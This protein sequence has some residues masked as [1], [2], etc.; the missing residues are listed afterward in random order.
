MSSILVLTLKIMD[1]SILL[2]LFMWGLRF[3]ACHWV[4]LNKY[5]VFVFPSA[6]WF[7]VSWNLFIIS[8]GVGVVFRL[9]FCLVW[10]YIVVSFH[11]PFSLL[12]IYTFVVMLL[13]CL[14]SLFSMF[15]LFLVVHK[16]L[17]VVFWD[18]SSCMDL[19]RV[20]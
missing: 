7:M 16:C 18:A 3:P 19:W 5:W 13:G 1:V 4:F 20:H 14:S 15:I 11:L 2:S 17:T 10:H 12:F 6:F 8:F 9:C